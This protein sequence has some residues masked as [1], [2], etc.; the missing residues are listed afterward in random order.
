LSYVGY[1]YGTYLGQAYAN[2]FPTGVR[3][4]VLDGVVNAEAKPIDTALAQARSVERAV[5]AVL[6]RCARDSQ[7]A[8]QSGGHPGPAFDTLT[9]RVEAKPIR[10]GNRQLG[11]NEFWDGVLGPLYD[12]DEG[13]L[14]KALAAAAQGSWEPLL[15]SADQ[16]SG[17]RPGAAVPAA[18]QANI[19]INCL[20]GQSV[21]PPGRF[22]QLDARFKAAAPRAGEFVLG[23]NWIDCNYWP[24]TPR[25]PQPPVRAQGA[26]PILVLGTTG[27]PVTPYQNAV[28]VAR[29]LD[30]GTLITNRGADHTSNALLGGPCDVEVIP[31]LV[32]LEIPRSAG[33]CSKRG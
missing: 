11:P 24:A 31:F 6:H 21:G 25:P 2:M 20:D 29:P 4:M 16:E 9:T 22:R 8:F 19:A 14:E 1:S 32:E 17:A 23:S 12:D 13:R 26:G 5:D 3:A 28:A 27:D 30:S 10:V 7:C 15:R 18:D 33:D